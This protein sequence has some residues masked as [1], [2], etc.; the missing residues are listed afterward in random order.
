VSIAVMAL[1]A[2]GCVVT[3]AEP[4][5]PAWLGAFPVLALGVVVFLLFIGLQAVV[6]SRRRSRKLAKIL[7]ALGAGS[8]CGALWLLLVDTVV[9]PAMPDA[10]NTPAVL[11]VGVVAA[12]AT[13]SLLA[14]PH[15]L[16][17]VVGLSA[18]AIGFHC[19]ALP[20]AALISVWVGGTQRFPA[21][22]LVGTR[23]AGDVR[24]VGLS[25]GGLLVGVVLVF[26]GDRAVRRRRTRRSRPRFDLSGP[27]A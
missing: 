2:F 21:A 12:L 23:L 24:T 15:R 26:V 16:S 13:A 4:G 8:V 14:M 10:M 7:V 20:I 18:M 5:K 22:G 19:L 25:V 6:S 3:E 9:T 1:A 27:H 17:A 11:L